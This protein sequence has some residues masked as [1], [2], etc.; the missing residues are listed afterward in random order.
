MIAISLFLV[1]GAQPENAGILN[2]P[3]LVPP[4]MSKKLQGFGGLSLLAAC[5]SC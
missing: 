3:V 5:I 2:P 4:I 1:S